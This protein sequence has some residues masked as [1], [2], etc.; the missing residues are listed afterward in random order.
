MSTK[1]NIAIITAKFNEQ[2]TSKLRDSCSQ[3]LDNPEIEDF[4]GEYNIEYEHFTC[5]GAVELIPMARHI[6]N[7]NG[8]KKFDAIVLIG[9]IIKG[10]TD[11]Y[12]YICQTVI[13][14]F[15]IFINQANIPVIFG[16]LTAQNEELAE[17]RANPNKINKG[18]DFAISTLEM[19]ANFH[20]KNEGLRMYHVPLPN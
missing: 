14:S 16:V 9:A 12:E 1:K 20:I 19:I 13:Q 10:D 3:Y 15:S 5:P 4:K 17:I 18:K 7:Q 2:I 8:K 6:L 11:H